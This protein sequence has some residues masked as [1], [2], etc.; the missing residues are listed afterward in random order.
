MSYPY[1][2]SIS[3]DSLGQEHLAAKVGW[4]RRLITHKGEMEELW[5]IKL[6]MMTLPEFSILIVSL[7]IVHDR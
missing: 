3:E 6:Q 4:K 2:C 7:I 1:L 5:E